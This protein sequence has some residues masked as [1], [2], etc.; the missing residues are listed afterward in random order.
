MVSW[1]TTI[2]YMYYTSQSRNDSGKITLNASHAF[3]TREIANKRQH[4]QRD[5]VTND[6]VKNNY[7]TKQW[8]WASSKWVREGCSIP[9]LHKVLFIPRQVGSM[10][11][12]GKELCLVCPMHASISTRHG[13]VAG[14]EPCCVAKFFATRICCMG[15]ACLHMR[16]P[17]ESQLS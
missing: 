7:D 16:S 14:Q 6:Q 10:A 9:K 4:V 13:D 5:Q 2:S 8:E 15:V 11:L 12:S 1:M 3:L 17:F